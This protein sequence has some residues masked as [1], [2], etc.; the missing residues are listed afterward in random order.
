V[1]SQG[2]FVVLV[3]LF[4]VER[5]VELVLS[6]SN[7]RW[8]M[9]RGGLESGRGHYPAMVAVHAGLLV[10]APLEVMVLGR[11]FVAVL[12]WP[13]LAVVVAAQGLRWWCIASLR[14]RWNT[15]V[16]VVHGLPLV[17]SGPYRWL[18]HPNY[19]AVVVEGIAFPLVHSAWITALTFTALNALVL[20][21]RLTTENAALPT[22]A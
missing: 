4:A 3:G 19:L 20:K 14:R 6:T 7:V 17:R 18:Q 15:R 21:T 11:P 13:M 12:G 8:A 22:S 10:A 2:W 1:S 9:A 5:C 16:V